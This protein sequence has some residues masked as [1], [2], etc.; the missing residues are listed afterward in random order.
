MYK[1]IACVEWL[2]YR[3]MLSVPVRVR[4]RVVVGV[5][6][7]VDVVGVVGTLFFSAQ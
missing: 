4:V 7:V 5:V 2:T 3:I 1:K 6:V